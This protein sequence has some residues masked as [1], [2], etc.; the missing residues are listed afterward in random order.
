MLRSLL[1]RRS[2]VQDNPSTPLRGG[3]VGLPRIRLIDRQAKLNQVPIYTLSSNKALGGGANSLGNNLGSL[4]LGS[5]LS[6]FQCHRYLSKA[7]RFIPRRSHRSIDAMNYKLTKNQPPQILSRLDVFDQ[8][9]HLDETWRQTLMKNALAKA[10]LIPGLNDPRILNFADRGNRPPTFDPTPH[11]NCFD[12]PTRTKARH[13][14]LIGRC[15]LGIKVQS[16]TPLYQCIDWGGRNFIAMILNKPIGSSILVFNPATTNVG[17]ISKPVHTVADI[18]YQIQM[19]QW[20][21]AG[22]RIAAVTD[23]AELRVYS[24]EKLLWMKECPCTKDWNEE[25]PCVAT[26]VTW[27]HSD[28]EILMETNPELCIELLTWNKLSGELVVR[29]DY[30][31]G[32]SERGNLN[33]SLVVVLSNLDRI[34]DVVYHG[35][36]GYD[37]KWSPDNTQLAISRSS[38]VK[39]WDFFGSE[40]RKWQATAEDDEKPN[41]KYSLKRRREI[42]TD[43]TSHLEHYTI[44]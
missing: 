44:R 39:I 19:L 2:E 30:Q 7:D 31:E 6:S 34:V 41:K 20:S 12:F 29:F 13:K 40:S 24:M 10:D 42:Y 35:R 23:N 21:H 4:R 26:L 33:R 5:G 43:H 17:T 18:I 11:Q 27:T 32:N 14:P 28:D 37:L 38:D 15:K 8:M 16:P 36:L 3:A 22:D 25:L 9:K 1:E